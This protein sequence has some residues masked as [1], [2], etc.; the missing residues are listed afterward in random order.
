MNDKNNSL[1]IHVSR[2]AMACEFEVRFPAERYPQGTESALHALD[3]VDALEEQL[4]YFRPTSQLSRINLLAAEEPVEVAPPLFDLLRLTMTLYDETE[5]AYDIT[6]APLWEAW[7]FARRSGEIPSQAQ[8]TEAR[9]LVGGHLVE[10]D[11]ARRTVRFLRPGV[12]LNLGSIGKGHALDVCGEQL[13]TLGMADFLLHGGQSSVLARGSLSSH[14]SV[15]KA[16]WLRTDSV[17]TA[18]NDC[19]GTPVPLFQPWEIGI[20]H[21]GQPG[22]R[23]GVVR[24]RNRALG[25]SG[26]QFQSF[27]HQGRR[28]GH[29]LDPRSGWPAEGVLSTTVVAP[30]AALADALST[31]FYVMGP[32]QSLA[33]CQTHPE[34]GVLLICPASRG[35]DIEIH[36]AGLGEEEL[37]LFDG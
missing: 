14:P 12:R 3:L 4:S 34:I 35:G 9:S 26:G 2:R 28:Y 33:Y 18:K 19:R 23:L 21:P 5:G 15:K 1:L 31:A 16:D 10:L 8:L 22:R 17:N 20:R 37:V 25:T 29:I 27:R 32:G 36:T 6:S 13:L 30:T 11:P 7:G 24:L